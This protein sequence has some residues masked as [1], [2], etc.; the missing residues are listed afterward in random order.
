VDKE[1]QGSLTWKFSGDVVLRC[2]MDDVVML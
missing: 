2:G 1:D